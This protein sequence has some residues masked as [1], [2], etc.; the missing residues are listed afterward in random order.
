MSTFGIGINAHMTDAGVI[1][2]RQ[3]EVACDCWFTSKCTSR[4][5]VV[6]FEGEDGE[7]QTIKNIQVI[8]SENKN[9]S[10]IPSI[11]YLCKAIIG[12]IMQEFK[13]IFFPAECRWLMVI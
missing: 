11:E 1:H 9:Y 4:P 10:G 6:K 5:M 2:G 13:L 7:I 12:G 8:V 3:F